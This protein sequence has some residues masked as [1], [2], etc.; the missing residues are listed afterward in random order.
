MVFI[1]QK[2]TELSNDEEIDLLVQEDFDFDER[3]ERSFFRQ[4]SLSN[5]HIKELHDMMNLHIIR[6][7]LI[8]LASLRISFGPMN[9]FSL[10]YYIFFLV[11]KTF[12]CYV[13]DLILLL[14]PIPLP[15]EKLGMGSSPNK[16]VGNPEE[17][18]IN[19]ASSR[20][21]QCSDKRYRTKHI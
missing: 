17:I 14:Y 7:M 3:S 15:T 20:Q 5:T 19:L 11:L 18:G 16:N 2:M 13:K 6:R 10:M 8:F 4:P 9:I 12:Q 21:P 1:S